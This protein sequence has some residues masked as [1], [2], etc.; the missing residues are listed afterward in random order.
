MR[1]RQPRDG[2]LT[3][4]AVK[5]AADPPRGRGCLLVMN[6]TTF[7][8]RDVIKNATYRVEVFSRAIRPLD[9]LT[10]MERSSTTTPR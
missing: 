4:N 6:D 9:T 7:N 5:V 1:R 10:G 2:Y 8:G 3:S